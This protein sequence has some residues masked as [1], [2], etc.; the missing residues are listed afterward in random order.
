MPI[1]K[2]RPTGPKPPPQGLEAFVAEETDQHRV[3]LRTYSNELH[4]CKSKYGTHNGLYHVGDLTIDHKTSATDKVYCVNGVVLSYPPEDNR[5]PTVCD[6]C[7]TFLDRSS[8]NIRTHIHTRRIYRH[9]VTGE[10]W[11]M[12]EI[13]NGALWRATWME[14]DATSGPMYHTPD[15]Q[16]WMGKTPDGHE[17]TID[18]RASNCDSPCKNCGEAFNKHKGGVDRCK[19]YED[20]KPHNC[21]IRKGTAPLF[22]V[23]KD[24]P[25]CG[26]GAGSILTDKWHG[27]LRAGRWITC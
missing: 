27:F 3:W 7:G 19:N 25:T 23:G 9:A 11:Q 21:W 13:P 6:A 18:G 16:I 1:R 10:R 8:Q 14:A 4:S 17:W 2:P 5:W 20:A 24:G 26:A 12:D 15:G 22:T